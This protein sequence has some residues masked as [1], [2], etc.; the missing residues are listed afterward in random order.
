MLKILHTFILIR[1]ELCLFGLCFE[2]YDSVSQG[3]RELLL[4]DARQT[5]VDI[6][7]SWVLVCSPNSRADCVF[8]SKDA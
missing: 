6:L 4:N 8:K 5:E 2:R 1:S 3:N 7:H